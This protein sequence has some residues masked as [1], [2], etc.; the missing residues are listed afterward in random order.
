MSIDPYIEHDIYVK[1]PPKKRYPIKVKIVS[2]KK[3]K[4]KGEQK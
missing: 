2:V 4:P 3:A 1:M